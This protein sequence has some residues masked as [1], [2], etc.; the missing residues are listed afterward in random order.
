MK[1]IYLVR[2][3]ETYFNKTGKVQ[4]WCDSLLTETG[5]AQAE[6][7]GKMFAE[8]HTTFDAAWISDMGRTRK[9]ANI[10]LYQSK[11][12]ALN[13]YETP[14]LRETSFGKFE[15]GSSEGMWHEVGP[16]IGRPDFND[17]FPSAEKILALEGIKKLDTL[18]IAENFTDVKVRA[19]RLLDELKNSGSSVILLVSHSLFISILLRVIGD[20]DADHVPNASITKIIYH[21]GHFCPEYIGK[22]GQFK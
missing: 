17:S 12:Q 15:G 11:N 21:E 3:G 4:G 8:N 5:I 6:R 2:H 1:T 7:V 9:T 13:L 22:V 14:L 19:R 20:F 10:I 16:V 18:K